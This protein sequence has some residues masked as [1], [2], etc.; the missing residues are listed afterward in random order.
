MDIE[1]TGLD[2]EKGHRIVEFAALLYR[3]DPDT[4]EQSLRG[5]FVQ[6]INPQRAID[7]GAQAVHGI[8]FED[9]AACPDWAEVAPKVVKVLSACDFLVAHNGDDFDM[10]F[11]AHELIRVGQPVPDVE[12]VDTMKQARWAT[13][14]GKL[15]NL[16]ELCFACG[17]DYDKAQAHG[18]EYDVS[19]M[20]ESF[21]VA[22]R[23]G[24]IVLPD[25][26]AIIAA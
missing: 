5:K 19:V 20:M 4:G 25:I 11:I 23:K 21:F 14:M 9:V 8:R 2:Y 17:V 3:F 18:A 24:F 6:R 12:S 13:P 15:P 1:T 10:P 7:P 26:K 22:H 16:G